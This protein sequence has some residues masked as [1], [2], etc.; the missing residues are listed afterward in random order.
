MIHLIWKRLQHQSPK[1][2]TCSHVFLFS[3]SNAK[4]ILERSNSKN[5]K[6]LILS[7]LLN[8]CGLSLE[9]AHS[10]S[11]KLQFDSIDKPDLVVNLL[12]TH[13]LTQPHIR[14]LIIVRPT[15]LLA[16]PDKTLKPNFELLRTLGVSGTILQGVL[17]KYPRILETNAHTVIDFFR[18]YGFSE[19]QICTLTM[20]LPTLYLYNVDKKFKPKLEFFKSLGFSGKEIAEMLSAEPY[21]LARSFENQILPSVQVIRRVVGTDESVLKAIKACYR[22]LECRLEKVLE[23]NIAV[24]MSNGV[25]KSKV[26][27][28]LMIQPKSFLISRD[29]FTEVVG[30]VKNLG[31]DPMSYLFILAIGTMAVMSKSLWERKVRL[32]CS[33][34][35]S[36]D[37][38]IS[39]FKIQPMCMVT[40]E[41]KIRRLMDFYV[42]QLKFKP[43]L[44][45]RNPNLLL[46]SLEKRIIPRC[47]VLH[48]LMSNNL[49]KENLSIVYAFTMTEKMFVQRYVCKFHS[50]MP[51]VVEA[52]QGKMQLKGFS[53]SLNM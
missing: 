28:L 52:H 25:P 40:S 43:S 26:L 41:E 24:L 49:I 18:A 36:N 23:P 14:N 47:S 48:L 53:L 10:A 19:K 11:K 15:L 39:A 35:M 1:A 51:E 21:I 31:F 27:K 50:V 42:N 4:L 38:V 30:E 5:P 13:G 34:G 7:F 9:S 46:F 16:D 33:F 44:I 45:S 6:S 37:E 22:L 3:T 12:K 32:F 8:S 17:K 2:L 29:R 20:K